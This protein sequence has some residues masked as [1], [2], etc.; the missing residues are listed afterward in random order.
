LPAG[1][2]SRGK[3]QDHAA[4]QSARRAI[5]ATVAGDAEMLAADK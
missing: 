5:D 4:M 3:G 2:I 1:S